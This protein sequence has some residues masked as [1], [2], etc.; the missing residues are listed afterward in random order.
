MKEEERA[1]VLRSESEEEEEEKPF[2]ERRV[3]WWRWVRMVGCTTGNNARR[4]TAAIYALLCLVWVVWM[5]GWMDC[6]V[7]SMEFYGL[8]LFGSNL[9]SLLFYFSTLLFV[10]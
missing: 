9:I 10:G 8:V 7:T 1:A 3:G 6:E 2:G 4:F 5:D